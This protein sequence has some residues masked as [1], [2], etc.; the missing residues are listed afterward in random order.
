M[1]STFKGCEVVEVG[2]NE[3]SLY[4]SCMSDMEMIM[5][6]FIETNLNNTSINNVRLINATVKYASFMQASIN[7]CIVS[8][9]ENVDKC[10]FHM[11]RI[12]FTTFSNKTSLTPIST[13]Y[14]IV[15]LIIDINSSSNIKINLTIIPN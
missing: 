2:F 1:S 15:N 3:S 13:N 4:N 7:E 6:S 10:Y 8:A 11:A 12:A 5:P 9:N 14:F